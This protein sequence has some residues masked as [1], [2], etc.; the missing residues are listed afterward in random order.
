MFFELKVSYESFIA[1]YHD[2]VKTNF[3]RGENCFFPD[4]LGQRYTDFDSRIWE[5]R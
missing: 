4:E 2:I 5:R 1:H 3:V